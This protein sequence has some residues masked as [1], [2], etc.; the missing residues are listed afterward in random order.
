MRHW[1]D[2]DRDGNVDRN[3]SLFAEEQL[4]ASRE[5]HIALFGNSGRFG[6][7]DGD[8]DD[9][10]YDTDEY[11]EDE[12]DEDE[13]GDDDYDD[14]DEEEYDEEEYE[15]DEDE[16]DEDEYEDDDDEDEYDENEFEDK[17][18]QVGIDRDA[19]EDMEDGLRAIVLEYAGIDEDEY[20][21]FCW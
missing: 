8:D 13:Y 21:Y 18:W 10:D 20:E 11:D 12:Y 16:D 19:L 2:L 6:D 7:D 14:D 17:L 5:E 15:D 3:E 1:R 9:D 4:C